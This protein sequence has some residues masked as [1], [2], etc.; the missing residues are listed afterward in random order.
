VAVAKINVFSTEIDGRIDVSQAV[1]SRATAMYIYDVPPGGSSSP[2]HYEYEEEWLLVLDGTLALRAPD[3][4]YTLER[5]DLVCFPAGP[6][7]A[8]KLMNRGEAKARIMMFSN[9]RTP[10]VTVY[11]DSDK[12]AV[13]PGDE[14]NELIFKRST[15][16]P[17]SEGE[18]GW[19]N[20]V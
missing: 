2:Y 11:P 6:A 19:E 18:E 15:A 12:I 16:V 14:A 9:D 3:G 5:G 7:G 4:E 1:G 8:H 10:A 20:V 13:W 17:Y